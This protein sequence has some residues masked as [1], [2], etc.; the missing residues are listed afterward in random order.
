MRISC[1]IRWREHLPSKVGEVQRLSAIRLI[2]APLLWLCGYI[3]V[4]RTGSAEA[5]ALAKVAW[6]KAFRSVS[7]PLLR[8][9]YATRFKAAT[10]KS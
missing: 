1:F 2:A 10:V 6:K 4:S 9:V 8:A 3:L 5:D 7:T